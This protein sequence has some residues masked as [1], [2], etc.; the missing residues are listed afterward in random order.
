MIKTLFTLDR[1]IHCEH[2]LPV[3]YKEISGWEHISETVDGKLSQFHRE[4]H[5]VRWK[6]KH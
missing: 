1:K 6:E 3:Q 4:P 2:I 5:L